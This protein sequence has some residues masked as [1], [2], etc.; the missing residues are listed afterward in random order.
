MVRQQFLTFT[1][2][3]PQVNPSDPPHAKAILDAA[4]DAALKACRDIDLK[5]AE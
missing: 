4:V 1:G 3:A 2:L 5:G